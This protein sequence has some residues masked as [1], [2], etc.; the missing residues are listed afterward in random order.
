M[1]SIN[2]V[3]IMG[4]GGVKPPIHFFCV[5]HA[6]REEGVQIACQIAYVINGR[7]VSICTAILHYQYGTND[8]LI[9]II[10]IN[11]RHYKSYFMK[12]LGDVQSVETSS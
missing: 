1:P 7:P 6:K 2:Y 9:E 8:L 4:E 12:Y 5:L 10:L 3:R 11:K